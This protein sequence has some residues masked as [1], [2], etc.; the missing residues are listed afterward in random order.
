MIGSLVHYN[1]AESKAIGIVTD[2]FRYEAPKGRRMVDKNS[3]MIS[4]EW[5]KFDPNGKM[6]SPVYPHSSHVF[7]THDESYWPLDWD[8]K[9]WYNAQWF[10]VISGVERKH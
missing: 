6:P 10:K 1:C 8:K 2:M 7:G 4:V 5:V 3:L 9:K